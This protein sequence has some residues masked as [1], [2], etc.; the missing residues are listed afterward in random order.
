MKQGMINRRAGLL[1]VF[2]FGFFFTVFNVFALGK[3]ENNAANNHAGAGVKNMTTLTG[4]VQ[5]YG[6]EPHT[7]VGI[8]DEYDVAYSIYPP[9]KEAELRKLQG[10]LI[11]FNVIILDEP[12]DYAGMVLGRSLTLIGWKVI[13]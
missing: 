1:T 11:E 7:F 2:L 12:Q 4:R 10:Y 13:K 6:N 5:V 9:N 3:K 8:V